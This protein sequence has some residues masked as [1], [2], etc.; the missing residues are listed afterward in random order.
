MGSTDPDALMMAILGQLTQGTPLPPE[1]A[2][3]QELGVKR[4]RLRQALSALRKS[5]QLGDAL[6]RGGATAPGGMERWT[7]VTNPVEVVELRMLLEPGLARLA[8][9][10]ASVMDLAR[11]RRAAT[12][13]ASAD[14]GA[15]DLAFHRAVAVCSGNALAG[16]IY[17]LLRRVGRDARLQLG[18]TKLACPSRLAQRDAEHKAI[19]E[20]IGARDPDG[21]ERAMRDHLV[22]VQRLVLARLTP[23]L[24][25]A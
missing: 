21:A 15:A 8:A 19:A 5:G 13:G 11:L 9:V 7:Q 12:T 17:V 1:R 14:P 2:L 23:G 22:N 10:R 20:A 6:G 16:E 4:H 25:V 24:A 3:A 18:R